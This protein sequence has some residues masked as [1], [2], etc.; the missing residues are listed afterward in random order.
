M[1][2][3]EFSLE[4]K[5]I[6]LEL[7]QDILINVVVNNSSYGLDVDTSNIVAGSQLTYQEDFYIFENI[8][9]YSDIQINMD[10]IN[11]L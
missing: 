3:K 9:S 1:T 6:G 8:L 10:E 11:M 7:Y 4:N 2:L 5:I